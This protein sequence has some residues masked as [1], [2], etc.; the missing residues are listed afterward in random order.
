MHASAQMEK[1][2]LA[3]ESERTRDMA[4]YG[5]GRRRHNSGSKVQDRRTTEK[6][7]HELWVFY[8]SGT[9]REYLFT[10]TGMIKGQ[11]NQNETNEGKDKASSKISL[12]EV[13]KGLEMY[14][15]LS[16]SQNV[17]LVKRRMFR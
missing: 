8:Q 10:P 17:L 11:Q 5:P 3:H 6:G 16:L 1:E 13:T 14:K 15:I 12:N 7:R 4:A 2:R 9:R